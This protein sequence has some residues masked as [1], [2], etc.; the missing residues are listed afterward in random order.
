[1]SQ[2]SLRSPVLAV[3]LHNMAQVHAALKEDEHSTKYQKQ[4]A[5]LL[6]RMDTVSRETRE[7]EYEIFLVKLLTLPKATA[8]A[9]AA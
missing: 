7:K 5:H 6:R 4:L 8:L 3:T 1:M 2:K 9:A